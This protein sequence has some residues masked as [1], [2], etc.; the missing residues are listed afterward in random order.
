MKKIAKF[1]ISG[2]IIGIIVLSMFFGAFAIFLTQLDEEIGNG[3]VNN[4]LSDYQNLTDAIITDTETI[5]TDVETEVGGGNIVTDFL[6]IVGAFFSG[7][8]NALT[9]SFNS[10]RLFNNLM[11]DASDDVPEFAFFKPYILAILIVIIFVG[12]GATV[13]LK[14]QV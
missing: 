4:V 5:K 12:I 8:W 13:L 11:D 1:T 9:T 2:F 3:N 6:D 7:G 14:M 10:F